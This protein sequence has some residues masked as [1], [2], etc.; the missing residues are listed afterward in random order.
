MAMGQSSS[1]RH[2]QALAMARSLPVSVPVWGYKGSRGAPGDANSGER[3]SR[4]DEHVTHTHTQYCGT[5][6]GT[7]DSLH[8]V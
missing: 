8:I 6:L 7:Q 3:V 2:Q 1:S 5:V 4:S